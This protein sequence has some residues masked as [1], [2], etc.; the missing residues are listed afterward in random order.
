MCM[1]LN[2]L[3]RVDWVF[4]VLV[5]G[6]LTWIA[7]SGP[8]WTMWLGWDG[9]DHLGAEYDSIARAIRSGRGLADPFQEPT[10]PTAW[11]PPALPYLL[12]GLYWLTGDDR[13][14][15]V[16]MI[17]FMQLLVVFMTSAIVMGEARRCRVVWAGY[18]VMVVGLAACFQMLFRRTH[19]VWL[20][21][22]IVNLLWLGLVA[23]WQQPRRLIY[24]GLLGG[25]TALCSPVLGAVWATLTFWR[26]LPARRKR[27]EIVGRRDWQR[28]WKAIGVVAGISCL[29]VLPWTIRNRV[30]LGSWMPIKSNGMFELWQSQCLDDDGVLD[31]KTTGQHP[32]PSN[33]AL[34]SE[35]KRRGEMAFIA[36]YGDL[37]KQDIA[38]QP[39]KFLD[40]MA[41][42][43]L[44][45]TLW[46]MPHDPRSPWPLW[47]QQL[48]FPIPFLAACYLLASQRRLSRQATAAAAIAGMTL[49]PYML[50]SYYDRYAAPLIGMKLILVL[51]AWR[52]IACGWQKWKQ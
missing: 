46:Y 36:Y 25:A 44:A 8:Q 52:G 16:V 45:A 31:W 34:R 10:G 14:R 33:G 18:F 4:L 35:Y 38:G 13:G 28:R 42:R 3:H 41:G 21:L 30:V 24:W 51:H 19:D 40:R 39:L 26:W 1:Y 7:D 43:G 48:I 6:G 2:R 29:C 50:I 17:W 5:I 12:A 11:M 37:A 22:L 20:N 47:L 9:R 32:W 15:V 49:A 23:R 27:P